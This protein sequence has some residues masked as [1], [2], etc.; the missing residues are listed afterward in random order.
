MFGGNAGDPNNGFSDTWVWDGKNWTMESPQAMPSGRF[1]HAMAYD[2]MHKQTVLFGGENPGLLHDTWIW[3]GMTW[4]Q[5]NPAS[6]PSAQDG[7]CCHAM[8]YDSTHGQVVLFGGESIKVEILNDTWLWDGTNWSQANPANSPAARYNTAMAYDSAHGLTVLFGG[9]N[10][11]G[12]YFGD[13]WVWDGTNWSQKMPQHNPPARQ[14]HSMAYDSKSGQVVMFGGV[15]SDGMTLLGDTWTWNG[16]DWTKQSPSASPPGTNSPA[17]AYD[18]MNDQTVLFGGFASGKFSANTWTFAAG[19]AA[20]VVNAVV[21]G[22]SFANGGVVPGEIATAFGT[23]I[24]SASGIN[25]TSPLPLPTEFLNNS[26]M[27]N[28]TAAPLFAVDNVNGQQQIN[29]QV[30]WEAASGPNANI[31]VQNNGVSSAALQVAV[32]AAQPG[33][34]NYNVGGKTFGAILHASFQLADTGHP[35]KPGET[36]LIYCTG[37]GAVAS[38]PADGAPGKGQT[39]TATPSVTIGGANAVVSFS[40]LAPGFVGLY[41]INA[42]VPATLSA[43]NQTVVITQSG[44]ASNQVLLPVS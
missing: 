22:A 32:L 35:A 5:M 12:T 37:L 39:T 27:V 24:T 6:N 3:D 23:N 10:A 34:F 11:G 16:T 19:A 43:G 40:G 4:T 38:P 30:P 18:S 17:L 41:Q 8:A 13:T 2:S 21:N 9:W 14:G 7:R 15:A 20:P 1:S 25:L 28:T 36:V 31:S 26:V 42:E 33:I 29:F 44:T